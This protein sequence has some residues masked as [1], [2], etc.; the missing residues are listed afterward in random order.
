M[1]TDSSH[2]RDYGNFAGMDTSELFLGWMFRNIVRRNV[3]PGVS[4]EKGVIA[5]DT[6]PFPGSLKRLLSTPYRLGGP[7]RGHLLGL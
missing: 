5:R 4:V 3:A 7:P 6:G 2:S 1:D